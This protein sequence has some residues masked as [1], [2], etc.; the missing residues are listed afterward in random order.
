MRYSLAV[1]TLSICLAGSP[2]FAQDYYFA[3]TPIAAAPVV[4]YHT[5]SSPVVYT[6]PVYSTVPVVTSRSIVYQPAYVV[7]SHSVAVTTYSTPTVIVGHHGYAPLVPTVSST[8]YSSTPVYRTRRFVHSP[9]YSGPVPYGTDEIE[10]EYKRR[11]HGG[12]KLEID[13]DD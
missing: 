7:P 4:S 13:F 8:W 2:T 11:R 5:Y 9:F 12:Y 6:T 1:L 10:L 3:P